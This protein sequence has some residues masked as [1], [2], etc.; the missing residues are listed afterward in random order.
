MIH[1]IGD[2]HVSVFSGQDEMPPIWN[3]NFR[4]RDITPYFKT[5]RIG[6]ATAYQSYSKIPIIENIIIQ[7][8]INKETDSILFCFG[9]VDIRAHLILQSYTQDKT[10]E[11]LVKECVDRYIQTILYFKNNGFNVLVWGPIASCSDIKPYTTG[12]CYGTE[13]ERNDTTRLFNNYLEELCNKN[14]ITFLSIFKKMLFEDGK[15][16]PLYLDNWDGCH[17]HLIMT[18]YDLIMNEFKNK[19]IL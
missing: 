5:Y 7:S 18:A 19:N 10:I 8:P 17:I 16:N 15:T 9:E 14:E 1:C 12:P 2:S 3:T 6:P 13:L 4:S 11:T